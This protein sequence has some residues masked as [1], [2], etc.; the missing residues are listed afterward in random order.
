MLDPIFNPLGNEEQPE[1]ITGVLLMFYY[2]PTLEWAFQDI[3]SLRDVASLG[4]L[5]EL[6]RWGAH[7]MVITVESKI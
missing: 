7:A 4:I 1:T 6:H 2:R 5:R 3:L